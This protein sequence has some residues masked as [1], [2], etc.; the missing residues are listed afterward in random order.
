MQTRSQKALGMIALLLGLLV[1]GSSAV[2]AEPASATYKVTLQNLTKGQPLSPPVAATHQDGTHVFEVGKL[3]TDQLAAIAQDGNEKP[4]FDLLNASG[5]ATDVVDV[6]KPLTPSGKKVGDF[7]DTV[8]FMIK[9]AP[10][11][12]FSLATMLICTN[13]GFTGLDSVS[14]P[15]SGSA[16]F[17]LNS[18]DA[19][20]E[21]N[22][23]KSVDIVDPCSALGPVKLTGDPNGNQDASVATN[24]AEAIKAHPGIKGGGDLTAA[25]HGWT[26]P[27]AKVTIEQMGAAPTTAPTTGGSFTSSL[28]W[29]M[30]VGGL[31]LIAGLTLTF[32]T[33]R[34]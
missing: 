19:G 15:A 11:E 21:N 32:S 31:L 5:K 6:G 22:T 9:G 12:K 23:E 1:L 20:R 10:G 7:S 29:A 25:D 18:Y 3:A 26:D 2:Y 17:M 28:F 8:T 16:S 30:L 4:A 27:V 33:R 14:L 24:P 13:D 34:S